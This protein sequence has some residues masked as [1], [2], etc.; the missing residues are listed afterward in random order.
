[1]S[2][3]GCCR[4][5]ALRSQAVGLLG[6]LR[7]RPAETMLKMRGGR[8]AG[9]ADEAADQTEEGLRPAGATAGRGSRVAGLCR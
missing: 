9:H 1:M 4:W 7:R 5:T 2:R 8:G 6:R 3:W